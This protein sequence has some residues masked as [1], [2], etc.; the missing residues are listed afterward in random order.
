MIV[1][2]QENTWIEARTHIHGL[3]QMLKPVNDVLEGESLNGVIFED[4]ISSHPKN[5]VLAHFRDEFPNCINL[6]F[7]QV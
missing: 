7:L 6:F 3:E 5:T 4:S 1:S 2:C